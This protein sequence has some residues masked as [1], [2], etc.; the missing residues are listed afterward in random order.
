MGIFINFSNHPSK[1]W[2]E[3]Q[4]GKA[5]EYGEIV[6]IPFPAVDP[7]ADLSEIERLAEQCVEKIMGYAPDAVMCQ[8]EFS[9][10]YS[11]ISKLQ[12]KGI[13]CLAAC[14]DRD[15]VEELQS[16]GT[17]CKTSKFDFIQFREYGK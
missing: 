2:G 8:G 5:L 3:K 13:Y 16:D 15:T 6:D 12:S 14:T 10:S 1:N 7:S 9:L 11:V 17:M 4:I